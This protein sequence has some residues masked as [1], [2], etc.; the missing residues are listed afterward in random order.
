[1]RAGP[2][3]PDGGEGAGGAEN[4]EHSDGDSRHALGGCGD[5]EVSVHTGANRNGV[6]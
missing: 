1:M 5:G 2:D 3:P 6:V 4:A